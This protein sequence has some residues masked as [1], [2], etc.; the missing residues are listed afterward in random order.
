MESFQQ[1]PD[2]AEVLIELKDVTVGCSSRGEKPC[3]EALNWMVKEGEFW[4][5][6]GVAGSGKTELISVAAGLNKPHKG[7]LILFGKEVQQLEPEAWLREKLNLGMVFE[8]GG[9]VFQDLSVYDNLI[10][11]L[12]YHGL[13][14]ANQNHSWVS[15]ILGMMDMSSMSNRLAGRL[16]RNWRQ[17]LGLARAIA[18][19]PEVLFLDNPLGVVDSHHGQWWLA[20]LDELLKGNACW[21][22]RSVVVTAS[23]LA[24]WIDRVNRIALIQE[25]KWEEMDPSNRDA[26]LQNDLVRALTTGIKQA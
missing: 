19:R 23:D 1:H 26:L 13:A 10:L 8:D 4:V 20:F 6:G 3:L 15:Q 16:S 7:A 22:P 17:R 5:L 18:L 21:K 24:P 12:S 25:G 9:R 11:P 2:A 14:D